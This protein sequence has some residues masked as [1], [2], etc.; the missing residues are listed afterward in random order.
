M[1]LTDQAVNADKGLQFRP[2]GSQLRA[3]RDVAIFLNIGTE[4]SGWD[5]EIDLR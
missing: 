4:P 3:L 5:R 2:P 1:P